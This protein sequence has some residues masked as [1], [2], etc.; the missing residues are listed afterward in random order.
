MNLET[1]VICLDSGDANG[2]QSPLLVSCDQDNS[3]INRHNVVHCQLQDNNT[4]R[5]GNLFHHSR[6]NDISGSRLTFDPPNEVSKC[7]EAQNTNHTQQTLPGDKNPDREERLESPHSWLSEVFSP[8]SITS[9]YYCPSELDVAVFSDE[10]LILYDDDKDQKYTTFSIDKSKSTFDVCKCMELQERTLSPYA[11]TQ[12]QIASHTLPTSDRAPTPVSPTSTELLAGDSPKTVS[13]LDMESPPISP[14]RSCHTLS[15]P[16]HL[17]LGIKDGED[18]GGDEDLSE[19]ETEGGQQISVVQ[20]KKL[21]YLLGDR[22]QNM[23]IIS[24]ALFFKIF[25]NFS[26]N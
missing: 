16:S 1:D 6:L 21:K 10:S 15:S 8:F 9:P 7:Y 12:S 19:H 17:G 13:D 24:F 14:V 23:V 26:F 18:D 4:Q 22:V 20:F 5:S 11:Q 3:Y 25:T 2:D